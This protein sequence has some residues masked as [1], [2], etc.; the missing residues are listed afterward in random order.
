MQNL[1]VNDTVFIVKVKGSIIN[2]KNMLK[3]FLGNGLCNIE[4]NVPIIREIECKENTKYFTMY[5]TI[6]D[7]KR[8]FSTV[9]LDKNGLLATDDERILEIPVILIDY[10]WTG[11]CY[12]VKLVSRF[13]LQSLRLRSNIF[14]IDWN[15]KA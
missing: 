8:P 6:R 14:L 4:D 5:V 15:Q 9:T 3:Q 10:L 1:Q 13:L 2:N 7:S 11:T 12:V